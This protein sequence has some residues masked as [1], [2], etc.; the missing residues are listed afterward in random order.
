MMSPQSR[1]DGGREEKEE[2]QLKEELK[3][4]YRGEKTPKVTHSPIAGGAHLRTQPA[5]HPLR[6]VE[7]RANILGAAKH[8][9][10]ALPWGSATW[11]ASLAARSSPTLPTPPSSVSNQPHA[12]VPVPA[13]YIWILP[14][15]APLGSDPLPRFCV[16]V[17]VFW[18]EER[19]WAL[20]LG[21]ML[22]DCGTA[23]LGR[24]GA[25]WQS[26]LTW[27]V[28]LVGPVDVP[29]CDVSVCC[30]RSRGAQDHGGVLGAAHGCTFPRHTYNPLAP[31][32]HV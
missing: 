19:G 11:L 13:G 18:G 32:F 14:F 6:R 2:S 27:L 4:E 30:C 8:G 31:F 1:T 26:R 24:G 15:L 25:R 28:V 7:L 17:C 29:G 3:E 22:G 20:D 16:F 5:T 23:G 10:L 9:Q 12:P 21:S